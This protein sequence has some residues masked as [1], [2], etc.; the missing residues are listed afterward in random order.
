[1]CREVDNFTGHW[2]D[3]WEGALGEGC[4]IAFERLVSA[5]FVAPCS[6]KEL[7]D[8]RVPYIQA[9][10][11]LRDRGL[12]LSGRRAE[13]IDRL[14]KEDQAAMEKLVLGI[15]LFR[16]TESGQ[17]LADR[18][19]AYRAKVERAAFDALRA[20]NADLAVRAIC[21]FQDALGFPETPS[22]LS[23]PEISKVRSVFS[24]RPKILASVSEATLEDL[25][26]AAGMVFLGL[27]FR[28]LPDGLQTGLQMKNESA[29]RM[30]VSHIQS[31]G[32]IQQEQE[33]SDIISGVRVYLSCE[34]SCDACSA[35]KD[36]E[37]KLGEQPELPY[38]HCTHRMGCR[39]CY[40]LSYVET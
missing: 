36:K 3:Q 16:C 31:S 10:Q 32:H 27:G 11:M 9:K 26:I 2:K 5:G 25:R 18:F 35:L 21:D 8:G 13:L 14:W 15:H 19:L 33:N 7:L 12:K 28:W 34:G 17:Q 39:C 1:M 30:I 29:I 20:R 22:F 23:N 40:G 37:W 6:A 38:E 4:D 24:A